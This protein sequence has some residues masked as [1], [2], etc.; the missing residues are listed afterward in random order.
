MPEIYYL[1]TMRMTKFLER[2][3][4]YLDLGPVVKCDFIFTF[5]QTPDTGVR[6]SRWVIAAETKKCDLPS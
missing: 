1:L 5:I 4:S 3:A 6:T 2:M